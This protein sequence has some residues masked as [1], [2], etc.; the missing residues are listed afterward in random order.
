MK[1]LFLLLAFTFVTSLTFATNN[2]NVLLNDTNLLIEQPEAQVTTTTEKDGP[3]ATITVD[4]STGELGQ[5]KIEGTLT[6]TTESGE[7]V[8]VSFTVTA[9]SCKEAIAVQNQIISAFE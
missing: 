2:T 9:D 8:S 1:N 4:K 5:C 7:S 3:I 6:I